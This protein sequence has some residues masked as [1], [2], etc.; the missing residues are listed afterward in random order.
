MGKK[1]I[2]KKIK[3]ARIQ[4][5][6]KQSD[7]ANE[8]G[9]SYQA[10]SNYE[11]GVNRIDSG[12]LFALC[13]LYNVPIEYILD[14]FYKC[15]DCGFEYSSDNHTQVAIHNERHKKW[16]NAVKRF[17][18]CWN[19]IE[20][21]KR[22]SARHTM[23]DE[24]KNFSVRYDA[25]IDLIK[26]Y[27]SRSVEGSGYDLN[28]IT[29]DEY[30]GYFLYSQ[31]DAFPGDIKRE[32]INK[33]G[34]KPGMLGSYW[35]ELPNTTTI[36]D[37]SINN[38]NGLT[39][40]AHRIGQAYEKA[41]QRDQAIVEHVLE[42]YM[43]DEPGNVIHV[44]FSDLQHAEQKASAGTGMFLDEN[45]MTTIKVKT[46]TLPKNYE[47]DPSRYFTVQIAGDSMEPKFY[48]GDILLISKEP[49][50][51]GDIGIFTMDGKGYLK[52]LGQGTLR[53]LNHHY[54]EFPL[55]EDIIC[56]GK[57]VGVIK[58]EDIG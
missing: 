21:E 15:P 6:L 28:H 57:V 10:I 55:T 56:N 37:S 31:K 12:T 35:N 54:E 8:L 19:Y 16:E 41:P 39:E 4:A 44:D 3:N 53:S 24:R 26:A 2:A 52:K 45:S 13:Q 33:Y 9:V 58:Q 38:R 22:H 1:E 32:L 14:E 34:S 5:G 40:I 51:V 43:D 23:R 36:E 20:R 42:P 47:K 46:D 49:V 30:I 27:F 7:V 25:A 11:R 29:F 17:G 18:F 50:N 48:D